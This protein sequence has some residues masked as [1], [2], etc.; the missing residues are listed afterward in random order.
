VT[1]FVFLGLGPDANSVSVLLFGSE[2]LLLL[3]SRRS[4]NPRALF[5]LP[6][7]FLFWAN[8]DIGFVYGIAVLALFLAVLLLERTGHGADWSWLEAPAVGIR[9]QAAL[10]AGGLCLFA[11]LLTP[12]TYHSYKE[13][14]ANQASS[15]NRHL[16]GYTSMS[17]HRSQD[18]VLLLLAMVAAL[19]LGRRRSR[20]LFLLGLLA[21][22][23]MLS[24]HAQRQ[25]W[26]VALAG[27]AVIGEPG[28]QRSKGMKEQGALRWR[29]GIL[30]PAA[31]A[32]GLAVVAWVVRVPA[33]REVLLAKTA[34]RFPVRACDYLREHHLPTPLFNPYLWGGFLTWYLP[35]YPVAIDLRRGLYPDEEEIAYFQVMNAEIPYQSLP[36]LKRAGTILLEKDS[37]M[38]EA[39]R[40]MPGFEV[41]YEDNVSLVLV[42]PGAAAGGK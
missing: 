5:A 29:W 41:A 27:V 32:M 18:Y 26:L 38:G 31:I 4:G 24:F 15:L 20:D 34:Q 35:G 25:N 14:I 33:S 16:P 11:S 36:A 17:F 13:F 21:G 28:A 2:L 12:Y 39:L 42:Q 10:A 7:L 40:D 8:L 22:C 1:Q 9:T 30:A 3:E 6:V 23:A 37:V 19:A